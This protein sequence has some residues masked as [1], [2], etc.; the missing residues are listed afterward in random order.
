MASFIA[1]LRAKP[2]PTLSGEPE[3]PTDLTGEPFVGMWRERKDMRDSLVST[4]P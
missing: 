2:R 4:A 3:K 1:S